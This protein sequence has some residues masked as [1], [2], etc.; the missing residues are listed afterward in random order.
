M[1]FEREDEKAESNFKKHGVDFNEATTVFDDLFNVDFY[2][3]K[4][5]AGERRFLIVGESVKAFN[6]FKH[7]KR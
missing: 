4:H 2:D 5:S 7:R 3:P 1:K 6:R